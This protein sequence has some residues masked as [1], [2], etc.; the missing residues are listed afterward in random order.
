MENISYEATESS[1]HDIVDRLDHIT[2]PRSQEVKDRLA[3]AHL[4]IEA[5]EATMLAVTTFQRQPQRYAYA[6]QDGNEVLPLGVGLAAEAANPGQAHDAG[7]YVGAQVPVGLEQAVA[8]IRPADSNE[9]WFAPAGINRG[10]VNTGEQ[11]FTF[12]YEEPVVQMGLDVEAELTDILREE[13]A[14]ELR[15]ESSPD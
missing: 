2:G 1:L 9:H 14:A 10:P 12:R 6:V 11:T 15:A 7:H 8:A 3:E 4:A 13:I 5:L